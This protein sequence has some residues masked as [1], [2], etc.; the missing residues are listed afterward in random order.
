[1]M[2]DHLLMITVA[3]QKMP[4]VKRISLQGTYDKIKSCHAGTQNPR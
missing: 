4:S 3:I 1:M 2:A